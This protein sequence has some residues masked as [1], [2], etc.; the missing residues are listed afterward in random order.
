MTG[1]RSPTVPWQ[2]VMCY[3]ILLFCGLHFLVYLQC[4]HSPGL[5]LHESVQ[6]TSC[7]EHMYLLECTLIVPPCASCIHLESQMH[8]HTCTHTY[9]HTYVHNYTHMHAHAHAHAHMW[10]NVTSDISFFLW[11]LLLNEVMV[12]DFLSLFLYC[13]MSSPHL[14]PPRPR[15]QPAHEW[16]QLWNQWQ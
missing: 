9:I 5:S 4:G 11:P 6:P 10:R 1:R 15:P 8:S 12:T 14:S 3:L 7:L 16:Q 13:M 2:L